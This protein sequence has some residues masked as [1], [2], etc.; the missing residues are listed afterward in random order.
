MA[1]TKKTT[2][3]LTVKQEGFACSVAEGNSLAQSYRDNYNAENMT[4]EVIWVKASELMS[5]GKV[6]VRVAELQE[7]AQE[8]T[9]VT[10]ASITAELEEARALAQK[11][12]QT[13]SMVSATMGK[14]KVNG[15]LVDQIDHGS[16]DGTMTPKPTLIK[17]TSPDDNGSD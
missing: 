8:R 14:A 13:A 17:L 12:A 1:A 6:L 3:G 4:N 2:S 15:L 7:A 11:T 9:L 5:N 16:S 10:M